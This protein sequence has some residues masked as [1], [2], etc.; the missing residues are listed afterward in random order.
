MVHL[1]M[2]DDSIKKINN[3]INKT[4]YDVYKYYDNSGFSDASSIISSFTY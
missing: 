3:K 4:P 1:P 2:D